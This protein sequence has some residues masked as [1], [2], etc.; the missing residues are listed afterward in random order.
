M[1]STRARWFIDALRRILFSLRELRTFFWC[2]PYWMAGVS[3]VA[4]DEVVFRRT[5]PHGT[6]PL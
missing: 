2:A 6:A 5:R 3:C 1:G 4:D